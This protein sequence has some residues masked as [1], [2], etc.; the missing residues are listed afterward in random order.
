MANVLTRINVGK[1]ESTI[2]LEY[3]TANVTIVS[4]LQ[5]YVVILIRNSLNDTC[6]VYMYMY[7]YM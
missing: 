5:V 1:E 6:T 7:M 2:E 4:Q 3:I